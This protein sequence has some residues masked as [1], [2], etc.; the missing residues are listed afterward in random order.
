MGAWIEIGYISILDSVKNLSHPLWVRG[1]KFVIRLYSKVFAIVAPF[2]GAWIEIFGRTKLR[3]L[4]FVAPFMG[5][6][7]EILKKKEKLIQ[8]IVAPFMG[9]WIEINYER[10]CFT[11]YKKSHPLWVRGLKFKACLR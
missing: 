6:W 8:D 10:D 7:I 2:M 11:N 9:A 4:N 1:L 3:N 5:A